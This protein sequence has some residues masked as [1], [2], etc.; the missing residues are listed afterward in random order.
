MKQ[1]VRM[2]VF[3]AVM[4]FL[5]AFVPAGAAEQNGSTTSNGRLIDIGG[6]RKIYLECQGAGSPTVIFISGR[7]DRSDIWKTVA[8]T[9]KPGPAVYPAVTQFTRACIYDRP[10]TFTIMGD[11]V[12]PSRST[13]TPQPT[14]AKD[15]VEDLHALLTA[16]KVPGPFVLVAHSWGG[17]IARLYA[18]TYPCDVVG[19]VLVD[20]LTEF[21]Y[22]NL[23]PEQRPLWVRLNSNYSPEL[24]RYVVQE[25]TDLVKSFEQLHKSAPLRPMPVV[26]L[27]SDQPFD[28][29]ALMASGVLPPDAPLELAPALWQANMK[30]QD[31]LARTLHAKHITDTHA[32]HYV[33]TEQ[34]Q[35][36]IDA[37]KEVVDKVRTEKRPPCIP[38]K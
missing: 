15:G 27:T 30:G 38:N 28:F 1:K 4:I 34:P 14:T 16:A 23:T 36:V 9:A 21:L 12:E 33:H 2:M 24:D 29:K 13:S 37:I 32:G 20:I 26:V 18:S 19:L 8:K 11:T 3:F 25:K 17:M 31:Q 5:N 10:G 35:L 22:D 6:G 7:S